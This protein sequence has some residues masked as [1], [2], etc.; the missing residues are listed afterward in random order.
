[1]AQERLLLVKKMVSWPEFYRTVAPEEAA[2]GEVWVE[3]E[4]K[5]CWLVQILREAGEGEP[6][7]R[8]LRRASDADLRAHRISLQV[9]EDRRRQAQR[10]ARALKLPMRF[11]AAEQ[12]LKGN[13]VRL[14]FVA[15]QRVDFRELVR[16]LS[17]A[18]QARVE[19]RQI[20]PRDAAKLVGGIGVC[21]RVLC[22][23]TFLK[24]F[25]PISVRMATEQ[26]LTMAPQRLTGLCGRLRCCLAFE[27]AQYRSLLEGLPKV[28][29]KVHRGELEGRIVGYN[30]FREVALVERPDG[31]RAE[32]PW[33]ELKKA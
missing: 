17:Q 10:E 8:L 14:F 21:G 9:A 1:L 23:H 25:Q 28:G 22:C 2:Q 4:G 16:R 11:V 3:K 7:G 5:N 13:F 12:S 30:I 27:H 20:G 29:T 31:T 26:S 32:I 19:L 18:F 24:D 6:H 33:E 15:P